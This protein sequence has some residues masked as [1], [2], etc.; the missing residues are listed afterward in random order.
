M[1][2]DP[3]LIAC[4]HGTREAA[5]RRA[6][7]QLRLDVGARRAGLVVRAANADVEVQRPGLDSV[8][9]RELGAGRDVVVVP[10][11]LSVGYHLAVDV[12]RAV[13]RGRRLGGRVVA[14]PPLGPDDV[15]VQVLDERLDQCG[16][17]AGG[18]VLL[19]AAGSSDPAAVADVEAM[20]R[21]LSLRRGAAVRAAYLSAARPS[22]ADALA[23]RDGDVPQ[24]VAT[25]LLAPG[26]FADRLR[27]LSTAAGVA[28][29][30]APLAPHPALAELVLR[31][32]DNAVVAAPG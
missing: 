3:V 32:F 20:G 27:A 8:V 13:E 1:S 12:A 11:L 7:A 15:L 10:L 16:A 2:R 14:A 17:P 4:A 26:F 9:E 25:Y 24:S 28:H 6:M 5:G 18:P 29:V 22:V 19:V 30:S 31:R 23:E 21:A